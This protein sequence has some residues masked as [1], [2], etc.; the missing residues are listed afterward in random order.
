MKFLNLINFFI[1]SYEF[2]A[3]QKELVFGQISK[4]CTRSI[5]NG[6]GVSN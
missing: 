2:K 5:V 3:W 6:R 1:P 4:L